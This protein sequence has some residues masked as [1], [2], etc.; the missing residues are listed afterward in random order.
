MDQTQNEEATAPVR[1][2]RSSTASARSSKKRLTYTEGARR[3]N[4]FKTTDLIPKRI[5][6]LAAVIALLLA[7]VAGLNLLHLHSP[8]W[9]TVIGDD[10]VSALSLNSG[11]GIAIWYSNFLLLLTSCVSLQLYLLRQHRRDD[12]RGSYRVWMWLALIFLIAS[13][14]SVT[15]IS[16]LLKNLFVN[17]IGSGTLGGGLTV[18]LAVKLLGL[19]LL[20]IRGLLEVRYSRLAVVTLLIVFAA[21]GGAALM[22]EVPHVQSEISQHVHAAQGNFL[23]LGATV[24]LISIMTFAR[25]VYL[26]ANGLIQP[27]AARPRNQKKARKTTTKATASTTKKKKPTRSTDTGDTAKRQRNRKT[28]TAEPIAA[29]TSSKKRRTESTDTETTSKRSKRNKPVETEDDSSRQQ[30]VSQSKQSSGRSRPVSHSPA[31]DRLLSLSE[32]EIQDLS[33]SERRRLRKLKRRNERQAA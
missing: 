9:V 15:G 28:K 2:K 8:E 22:S 25:Y 12:Y 13:A 33:K 20:V 7:A 1:K 23:L 29:S 16:A 14:A 17:T 26:E 4:Q 31:D 5:C 19:L 27:R 18:V 24:L 21:Y 30:P 32:D 6:S 3:N 10:G 11:R